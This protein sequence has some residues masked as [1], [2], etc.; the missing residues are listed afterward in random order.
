MRSHI[1]ARTRLLRTVATC[2]TAL[3]FLACTPNVGTPVPA[4]ATVRL[5]PASFSMGTDEA[6][7]DTLMTRYPDLPRDVFASEA[8]RHTVQLGAYKID[9][10]EV[11]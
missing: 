7:I 4:S 2:S 5:G 8:P 3:G 11:T 6:E 10:Y 1:D 9:R